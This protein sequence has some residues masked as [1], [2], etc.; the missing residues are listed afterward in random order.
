V[1]RAD[2]A[3][4]ARV[5]D[6]WAGLVRVTAALH[7]VDA[8]L[9]LGMVAQESA[10]DAY[11]WRA[12]PQF[13][14]NYRAGIARSIEAVSEPDDRRRYAR[15]FERDPMLLASSMGLMQPLLVVAI[16]R[17]CR[18]AYPT[19]LCDAALN[20]EAGCRQ[21]RHCYDQT[22]GAPEPQV[23]ALLRYNGGGNPA[24]PEEVIRWADAMRAVERDKRGPAT[25]PEKE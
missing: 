20:L 19:S 13:L 15:W 23:A 22:K 12:E 24:Y 11:A 5:H 9:V 14:A 3:T 1:S 16:E 4:A 6:R 17:G 18:L 21:L 8:M 10:G 2:D 7:R 25:P